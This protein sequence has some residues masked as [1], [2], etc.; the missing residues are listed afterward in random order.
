MH[1]PVKYEKIKPFDSRGLDVDVFHFSFATVADWGDPILRNPFWRCYMPLTPGAS[2]RL[3]HTEWLMRPGE[4][5]LIPPDSPTTGY[6]DGPF[7]IN[8]A[9]FGCSLRLASPTPLKSQVSAEI[10]SDLDDAVRQSSEHQLRMAMMRLV[11]S[12]IGRIPETLIRTHPQDQYIERAYRV[13]KENLDRRMTNAELAKVLGMSES[14]VL[15]LFREAIGASPQKEHLRL[16]LERAAELLQHT[17]KSIDEIA[18]DCGFWDRN[19]FSRVFSR[20]WKTP[21]AR[22][23]SSATSL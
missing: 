21:P 11:V 3:T 20:E 19:H 13:M 7:S 6:A 5:Y 23:R 15:R 14:T 17:Q 9:H 1:N 22:Y 12:A 4:V 2:L 8:Y 10:K 16:R 18:E